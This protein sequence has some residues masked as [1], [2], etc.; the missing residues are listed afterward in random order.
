MTVCVSFTTK[1]KSWN[2]VSRVYTKTTVCWETENVHTI[3]KLLGWTMLSYGPNEL[4]SQWT[5]GHE[6]PLLKTPITLYL[7][8]MDPNV[9]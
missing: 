6:L 2:Y 3:I 9:K 1:D 5:T 7:L 8:K 4:Q